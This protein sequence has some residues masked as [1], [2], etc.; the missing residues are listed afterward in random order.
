MVLSK[1]VNARTNDKMGRASVLVDLGRL[2]PGP[3]VAPSSSGRPTLT[4]RTLS[5]VARSLRASH[6]GPYRSLGS[7]V[8]I[9]TH[10]TCPVRGTGG[11][12]SQPGHSV[13]R[14]GSHHQAASCRHG[15]SPS[16]ISRQ[17]RIVPR[18]HPA[19]LGGVLPA[20]V[21]GAAFDDHA[22]ARPRGP[23]A[24]DGAAGLP[25]RTRLATPGRVPSAVL[26][27]AELETPH[28]CAPR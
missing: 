20:R 10:M 17:D 9:P 15:R 14:V 28:G 13:H 11:G 18:A 22:R 2:L 16:G 8:R 5:V 19:A 12:S 7:V 4:C 6:Q 21:G 27:A 24:D 1:N 3:D 23:Q 26:S 25:R